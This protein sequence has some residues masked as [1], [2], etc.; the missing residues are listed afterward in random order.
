M[1]KNTKVMLRLMIVVLLGAL[2]LMVFATVSLRSL[3]ANL[4]NERQSKTHEQIETVV[5]LVDQLIK[6][7]KAEGVPA[8]AVQKRAMQLISGLR[9]SGNQYFW[10]NSMSGEMLMHPTNPKLVGTNISELKDANGTKFFANMIDLVRREGGGFY[11]YWW[12]TPQDPKPREKVSYVVGVPQWNWVIGTGIYID[13]VGATFWLSL[14]H[15]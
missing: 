7:G 9:Y 15:I 5:S 6:D 10:I 3:N 11:H 8:E 4:L 14:I 12:Q 2:G 1:F 13:D